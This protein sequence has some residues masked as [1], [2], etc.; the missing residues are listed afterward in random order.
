MVEGQDAA[1]EQFGG[2]GHPGRLG[3]GKAVLVE[4]GI[5]AQVPRR[6]E[7]RDKHV[8]RAIALGLDNQLAV[9]LERGAQQDGQGD[10]F[11]QKSRHRLG[12]VMAAQNGVDHRTELHGTATHIEAIDLER[13]N[14]V[15]TGETRF[16][17]GVG[18]RFPSS[19]P[20][21]HGGGSRLRQ[22]R[23]CPHLKGRI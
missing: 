1:T 12:V 22:A 13:Q 7:I 23:S 10:G 2:A 18:Y 14:S 11:G 5:G 8:H 4:A 6:G 20:I 19:F 17:V 9:E 3:A 15:V 21:V 16:A